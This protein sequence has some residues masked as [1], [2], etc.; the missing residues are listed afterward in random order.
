MVFK[1]CGNH[2]CRGLSFHH[3]NNHR[4]TTPPQ[5]NQHIELH[6]PTPKKTPPRTLP[7][8][9]NEK[10]IWPHSNTSKQLPPVR[11]KYQKL[12]N[13]SCKFKKK[14][15]KPPTNEKQP[16]KTILKKQKNRKTKKKKQLPPRPPPDRWSPGPLPCRWA[17]W[18]PGARPRRSGGP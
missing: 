9:D 4:K 15:Q 17:L 5:R 12:K 11:N 1:L 18:A 16:K 6:T 8:N 10:K 13:I 2:S 3:P 7:S 14:N